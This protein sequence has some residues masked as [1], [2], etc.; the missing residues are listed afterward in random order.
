MARFGIGR[1]RYIQNDPDTGPILRHRSN[2]DLKDKWRNGT[3]VRSS[4]KRKRRRQGG[5][6]LAANAEAE[7]EAGAEAQAEAPLPSQDEVTGVAGDGAG[8]GAGFPLTTTTIQPPPGGWG[9][10]R[11]EDQGLAQGLSPLPSQ[12][13][14]TRVAGDGAGAG[15]GFPPTTMT[16]QPPPGGRGAPRDRKSVV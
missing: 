8:A 13:E 2:V 10:F 1:W 11:P 16:I 4:K 12:D 5:G 15:P 9:A 7:A 6:S 14:V 3:L